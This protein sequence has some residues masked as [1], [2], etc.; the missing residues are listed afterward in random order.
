M[1]EQAGPTTSTRGYTWTTTSPWSEG[2][3]PWAEEGARGVSMTHGLLESQAEYMRTETDPYTRRQLGTNFERAYDL[4]PMQSRSGWSL[5]STPSSSLKNSDYRSSEESFHFDKG[6]FRDTI[7]DLGDNPRF[8]W[9]A[10][11]PLPDKLPT[12]NRRNPQM[13]GY[14]GPTT[15]QL[16]TG[17]GPEME[18]L[19]GINREWAGPRPTQPTMEERVNQLMQQ[20]VN[21]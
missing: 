18:G 20:M 14:R 13:V 11:Y 12:T 16:V 3:N 21:L 4:E 9:G 8:Y 19:E 15:S 5:T 2:T 1:P 10:P 6:T 17:A 7:R